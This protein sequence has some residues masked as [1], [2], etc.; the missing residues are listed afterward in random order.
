MVDGNGIPDTAAVTMRPKLMDGFREAVQAQ[1][2]SLGADF[3]LNLKPAGDLT[4]PT[5]LDL[6]GA[7]RELQAF[8]ATKHQVATP[9][10]LDTAVAHSQLQQLRAAT[11]E[12]SIHI[13]T[14]HAVAQLKS[15][16]ALLDEVSIK[17]RTAIPTQYAVSQ[18]PAS[19]FMQARAIGGAIQGPGGPRD[20]M[21]PAWLSNGEYVV[22]AAATAANRPLLDAINGGAG[23]FADGGYIESMTKVV[24]EKFP[25]LQMTSG[26]RFTD[27]GF[28]PR[29]QA[30]DFSNVGAGEDGSPAMDALANWIADN[31]KDETVQLIHRPFGRNIGYDW[32]SETDKSATDGKTLDVGDGTNFYGDSTMDQHRDHVHWAVRV[33][34][35]SKGAGQPA[36]ANTQPDKKPDPA[37]KP[38][39][40]TNPAAPKQAAQEPADPTAKSAADP[41]AKPDGATKAAADSYSVSPGFF[42]LIKE[43]EGN[44]KPGRP[45][46]AYQDTNGI[47]TIGYGHT[48][49]DVKADPDYQITKEQA[50]EYLRN[51]AGWAQDAVRGKVK[52]PITQ[53][54]FDALTSFTYNLGAGAFADS[55]VL[56]LLNQGDYAGAQT[57]FGLFVH[58]SNGVVEGLVRRR[59]AE[60]DLFGSTGSAPAANGPAPGTPGPDQ[61]LKQAKN[62]GPQDQDLKEAHQRGTAGVA[63]ADSFSASANLVELLKG[64]EGNGK[65]GRPFYAYQDTNG[66][67][68]IGYGHTGPDVPHNSDARITPEQAEEYLRNDTGWAQDAVRQKV[69]VPINQNQFDALTSFTYNLGAGGLAGSDVLKLLNQGD[70]AGAQTAFGLFVHDSNGVVEGLVRRRKAEADLF[71]SPVAGP[72]AA[73]KPAPANSAPAQD[74]PAPAG[75]PAPAAPADKPAPAQDNSAPGDIGKAIVAAARSQIGVPYAWGGGGKE[76]PGLGISDGGGDAD[77]N[78]DF[79]KVGFDC[80]HLVEYAVW[81][82]TGKKIDLQPN[83]NNQLQQSRGWAVAMDDLQPGDVIWGEFVNGEPMHVGIV[84]DDVANII[85]APES[86]KTIREAKRWGGFDQPARPAK[87]V[88]LAEGGFVSGPGGPREDRVPALLSN[89]EFVVNAAATEQHLPLLHAINNG[90]TQR[91]ADG[92]TVYSTWSAMAQ[93]K[94]KDGFMKLLSGVDKKQ[95]GENVYNDIGK[96]GDAFG[97]FIGGNVGDA[98]GLIGADNIPYAFQAGATANNQINDALAK[99]AAEDAKAVAALRGQ[100][101]VVNGGGIKHGGNNPGAVDNS[102][103]INITTADVDT[104]FQKAKTYEAQRALTFVGR[105]A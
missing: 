74:N 25:E 86:G 38:Q 59:K 22:N 82:G 17:A 70:Y 80:S 104:A 20:D 12:L 99:K 29:G 36:P 55:D 85:D 35:G 50:E 65:P 51:D 21:I 41:A 44:G 57:A 56:K 87:A 45:Y 101:P 27:N 5:C 95:V 63:S 83:A 92:G 76:G 30:A 52:T 62:R 46:Y 78:R 67:W 54:Q 102:M 26:L 40:G 97:A 53:A 105:W 39:A 91:F 8:I 89:G 88:R 37:D 69:K 42:D 81:Q 1:L 72:D 93:D 100:T 16:T 49:P 9:V 64:F 34:V 90:D 47:W 94:A 14:D 28:H 96:F 15:L 32:K 103:I 23:R 68:T 61:N 7:E 10:A 79:E 98:L 13:D 77:R 24:Q 71:G 4:V 33:P 31:Y 73:A 11:G 43:F 3:E 18:P 75:N 60:A 58:D 19:P 6:S 84:A 48:G 2:K 66:I